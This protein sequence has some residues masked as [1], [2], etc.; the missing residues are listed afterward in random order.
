MKYWQ[1]IELKDKAECYDLCL[2]SKAV[3]N[4]GQKWTGL[5]MT[6]KDVGVRQMSSPEMTQKW[7][8]IS[9]MISEC[10]FLCAK[11][12][13]DQDMYSTSVRTSSTPVTILSHSHISY[14]SNTPTVLTRATAKTTLTEY[15]TVTAS[16]FGFWF[17]VSVMQALMSPKSLVSQLRSLVRRKVYPARSGAE[18]CIRFSPRSGWK[19]SPAPT[20]VLRNMHKFSGTS[21]PQPR[22]QNILHYR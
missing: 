6:R 13:C 17:G 1:E 10:E 5:R 4:L 14:A 8:Q 19:I 12:D 11:Q 15:L 9:R 7:N 18:K 2:E 21:S 22:L 3:Q 16:C 20:S